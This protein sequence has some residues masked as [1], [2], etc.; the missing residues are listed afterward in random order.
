M[1]QVNIKSVYDVLQEL[2]NQTQNV[3]LTE[4]PDELRFLDSGKVD[5]GW[6]NLN[7]YE[8]RL[9]NKCFA[10][11]KCDDAEKWQAFDEILQLVQWVAEGKYRNFPPPLKYH[12]PYRYYRLKSLVPE[13]VLIRDH[14]P[15]QLRV[16]TPGTYLGPSSLHYIHVKIEK[17]PAGET[18]WSMDENLGLHEVLCMLESGAYSMDEP[19]IDKAERT[20][21][22]LY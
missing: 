21:R 7:D 9:F 1:V 16:S 10:Q 4:Y 12:M 3:D 18:D 17:K 5:V 11:S 22:R 20:F 8:T 15:A 19:D 13:E 2:S 6:V 14:F